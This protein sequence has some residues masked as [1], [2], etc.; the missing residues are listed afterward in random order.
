MLFRQ[1]TA[2]S[3]RSR[4]ASRLG[5][6]VFAG[7]KESLDF[8]TSL[9][10]WLLT[11]RRSG[12]P[13]RRPMTDPRSGTPLDNVRPRLHLQHRPR[14]QRFTCGVALLRHV[15]IGNPPHANVT[16]SAPIGPSNF[17]YTQRLQQN[18]RHVTRS[19]SYHHA[20]TLG[21]NVLTDS[22]KTSHLGAII[23]PTP[24][25]C[26]RASKKS[27]EDSNLLGLI[28]RLNNHFLHGPAGTTLTCPH[29]Y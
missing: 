20:S 9:G 7:I 15:Q 6:G 27:L 8:L 4:Q 23:S 10:T 28:L 16:L 18:S 3:L 17:T 12:P 19:H 11:W 29:N 24:A 22:S 26:L 25:N 13:W 2:C 1:R 14:L 21:A 5:I